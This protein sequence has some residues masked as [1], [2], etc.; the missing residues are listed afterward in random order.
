MR[1]KNVFPNV[2]H[3][4]CRPESL[5]MTRSCPAMFD[6]NSI[7]RSTDEGVTAFHCLTLILHPVSVANRHHSLFKSSSICKFLGLITNIHRAGL[8]VRD[9]LNN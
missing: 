3:R 6:I 7:Q 5:V 9:I 4:S 2:F 1:S 8:L